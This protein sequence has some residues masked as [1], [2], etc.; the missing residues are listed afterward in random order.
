M[1]CAASCCQRSPE[2]L[3]PH[4]W[5]IVCC[6]SASCSSTHAVQTCMDP[7]APMCTECN[8]ASGCTQCATRP[9]PCLCPNSLV[10]GPRA[11]AIMP[12]QAVHHL[13]LLI[14][15]CCTL[16]TI[17]QLAAVLQVNELDAAAAHIHNEV[18]KANVV[19]Q[20]PLIVQRTHRSAHSTAELTELLRLLNGVPLVTQAQE[21]CPGVVQPAIAQ[22]AG[23]PRAL[24]LLQLLVHVELV[25]K[26]GPAV[27]ALDLKHLDCSGLTV[28]GSLDHIAQASISKADACK[29]HISKGAPRQLLARSGLLAGRLPRACETLLL[30][31]PLHLLNL[32]PLRLLAPL[33]LLL[34]LALSLCTLPRPQL[35][36][37]SLVLG[38][39]L[40]LRTAFAPPFSVT[41]PAG[42]A[43]VGPRWCT[44]NL[45]PR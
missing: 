24:Q 21:E 4:M 31:L 3:S 39:L 17:R 26:A 5:F 18:A 40:L 14:L 35:P 32:P 2:G 13:H 34:L 7:C 41:I 45:Q 33:L 15:G 25:L 28:D 23:Q 16:H 1:A 43:L 19:V 30:P 44:G 20:H 10:P 12:H 36:P 42:A 27:P 37:L 38:L 9:K 11:R 22:Q 8:P 29:A 6:C